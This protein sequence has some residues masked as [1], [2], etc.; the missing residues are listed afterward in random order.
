M[1]IMLKFPSQIIKICLTIPL[2]S[3]FYGCVPAVEADSGEYY[4]DLK[5]SDHNR[6]TKNSPWR[7]LNKAFR[8]VPPNQGKVI[9]LGK[10]TFDIGKKN[11]VPS[12]ITLVG[13]GVNATTIQGELQL[14]KIKN[15]TIRDITFN[16]K[17]YAYELGLY[18]R[19]AEKLIIHD[20]AFNAYEKTAINLQRVNDSRIYNVTIKDSSFNKHNPGK[21]GKQSN[22]FYLGDLTNFSLDNINI[23]T[24]KRGGAGI[25]TKKDDWPKDAWNGKPTILKNVTFSNLDIKVD[26]WNAW[27]SGWTPQMALELWHYQC[28]NCEIFNSTFNSTVSLA[29]PPTNKSTSIRVYNNLWYGP[30]NPFYALEVASDNLEIHNNYIHGG[31]YPLALFGGKYR[32]INVHHNLFENTNK[33]TLI[34]LF[35]G[36]IENFKFIHNTVVI[37]N[38]QDKIF[39]FK[40]KNSIPQISNNIFYNSVNDVNER[41]GVSSGVDNNLFFNIN[42]VGSRVL[43]TNPEFQR[44]GNLPYPYYMP[45]KSS[46]ALNFG[47]IK[48]STKSWQVGKQKN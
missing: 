13:A 5:G 31:S 20:V 34:G 23:D 39:M 8:S 24:R 1:L 16:G 12:G 36:E 30:N 44:T 29:A 10:G 45:K 28:F 38:S 11:V 7:S 15:L 3:L 17:N 21:K 43:K 22:A 46:I 48:P 2:L 42:P 6:G 9:R 19:D 25:K 33:P 14:E 27:G 4:V 41:L 26:K 18:I 32:N 40:H 35:D 47:A 37:K